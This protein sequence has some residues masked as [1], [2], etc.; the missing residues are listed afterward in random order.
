MTEDYDF[1]FRLRELG[2]QQVFVRQSVQRSKVKRGFWTRKP[3]SVT[4]KENIAT[5]EL[6]P[7]TFSAAVRQ[8]GRWVLGIALQGWANLGWR[9]SGWTKYMLARDR[10]ALL[11]NQ[12]N[13][14]GYLVLIG[15]VAT[16]LIPKL[17]PDAY[18]YPPLVERGTWLWYL[19]LADTFFLGF[20]VLARA[21]YVGRVYG[22]RQSLLSVLRQ[23]WANVINFAA[24]ARACWRFG[25]HLIT[26]EPIGWEKTAHSFPSEAELRAFRRKLGDLLVER[27]HITREQLNRALE[28]QKQDARPLG[29]VLVEMGLV[30]E[31]SLVQVLGTQLQLSSR[32][33]DPYEI[34]TDLL[35][36]FPRNSPFA[37]PFSPS[38]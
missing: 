6:F 10:K 11:T 9:G 7:R 16:W 34:P 32:E 14:L 5:R 15:L 29:A 33:I 1:A 18:R 2:L 24:S 21:T 22:W 4:V 13:L 25:R 28:R 19:I 38:S 37:T 27:R 30:D 23:I 26:G 35:R 20:R 12:I 17:A 31:S 36:R 8:K 3:R